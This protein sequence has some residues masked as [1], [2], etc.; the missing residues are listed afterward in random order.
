MWLLAPTTALPPELQELVGM[1]MGAP[2]PAHD[3]AQAA[4]PPV[5]AAHVTADDVASGG[6]PAAHEVVGGDSATDAAAEVPGNED[7]NKHC[8]CAVSAHM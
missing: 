3:P 1:A 5:A 4:E 7:N 8:S 6:L 2:G